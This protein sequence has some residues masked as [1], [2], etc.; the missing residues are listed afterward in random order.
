LDDVGLLAYYS[1]EW[2]AMDEVGLKLS[3]MKDTD[4]YIQNDRRSWMKL[5]EEDDHR[6]MKAV[7]CLVDQRRDG[8]LILPWTQDQHLL[9]YAF[10]A[11][12]LTLIAELVQA[13]KAYYSTIERFLTSDPLLSNLRYMAGHIVREHDMYNFDGGFVL[14]EKNGDAWALGSIIWKSGGAPSCHLRSSQLPHAHTTNH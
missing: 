11:I 10:K 1:Y 2:E 9:L 4:L 13:T 3:T 6:L 14:H 5:I 7:S 12:G 8:H